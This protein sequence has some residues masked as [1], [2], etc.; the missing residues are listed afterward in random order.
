MRVSH[1]AA[2]ATLVALLGAMFVAMG[3]ASAQGAPKRSVTV[4]SQTTDDPPVNGAYSVTISFDDSDGIVEANDDVA[5]EVLVKKAD[6]TALNNNGTATIAGTSVVVAPVLSSAQ[7]IT[8]ATGDITIANAAGSMTPATIAVLPNP[9]GTAEGFY[10]VTVSFTAGGENVSGTLV[11]QRADAGAALDNVE[12]GLG[13]FVPYSPANDGPDESANT[14]DDVAEVM[15]S[16]AAPGAT[17]TSDD[18]S[19]PHGDMIC[20]YVKAMNSLGNPS[21]NGDIASVKILAPTG[22]IGMGANLSDKAPRPNNETVE[23][24][25]DSDDIAPAGHTSFFTVTKKS[26]GTV[27]VYAIVFGEG[28]LGSKTTE[29]VTLT[30]TGNP[31]SFEVNDSTRTLHNSDLPDGDDEGEDRD[32]PMIDLLVTAMDKGGNSVA[33]DLSGYTITVKG[34]DGKATDKVNPVMDGMNQLHTVKNKQYLRLSGTGN[35]DSKLETGVYMVELKKAGKSSTAEFTVSAGAAAVSLEVSSS[36]VEVNDVITVTATVTDADG[37]T[38]IEGTDVTFEVAGSLDLK[39]LGA[40]DKGAVEATTKD[41][42]AMARVLVSK[43]SGSA[44]IVVSSGTVYEVISVSTAPVEEE[45]MPEEEAL[46]SC[47]SELSGF[48]TWSCGV[49]AD[50]SEIFEMVSARGVSAIHLWNGSTW[51][52]YSVVDDAMVPGSSDFMVTENDIL[53][54]SN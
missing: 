4:T 37:N 42:V 26:P 29:T 15:E 21:S 48:A 14:D 46:V 6:G 50:A 27:V 1:L 20:L 16:C 19:A 28:A 47:L 36:M 30:F 34:T 33:P 23:L 38:V 10:S 22:S 9:A 39:L 54:I 2:M 32:A 52:R 49:S 43:G 12:I 18:A 8:E 3:S 5:I 11:L 35:A 7:P 45:A 51:V 17:E 13:K 31:D 44:S 25:T 53:Y 24:A 41:G 40:N